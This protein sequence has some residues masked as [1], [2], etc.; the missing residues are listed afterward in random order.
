MGRLE[1]LIL[2][3]W[4]GRPPD[5]WKR[6]IDDIISIWSGTENELLKFLNFMNKMFNISEVSKLLDLIDP[7]TKK[8]QNHIL[9]YWEKEFSQIKPKI[10]NKR[11]YYSP[12]QIEIVKLIKF[13]LILLT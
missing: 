4:K 3:G 12:K 10:I 6:Y 5:L 13:L 8:P 2:E 7:V 9:R 1:K 11:R